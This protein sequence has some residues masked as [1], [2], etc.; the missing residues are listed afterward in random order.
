[1]RTFLSALACLTLVCPINVTA[2]TTDEFLRAC[3]AG[4]KTCVDHPVLRAYLGGAMDLLATLDEKTPYL[5]KIYCKSPEELFQIADIVD[6]LH[7]HR[8]AY[9]SENAMLPV[10]RYFEEFGGCKTP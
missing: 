4:P 7:R 6:Y 9:G 2:L 3:E 10:V 1:M 8:R 5:A